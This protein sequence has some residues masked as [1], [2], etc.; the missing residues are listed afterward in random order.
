MGL[1]KKLV[2]IFVILLVVV[3]AI[4]IYVLQYKNLEVGLDDGQSGVEVMGPQDIELRIVL[5]FTNTGS[6]EL[7][8]PPTDFEVWVDGIYAGPGKSDRV[9]VPA[10][11]TVWTTAIVSI[12]HSSVP[13]AFAALVDPGKDEIRLKGEAHVEVGPFTFDFPFDETYKVE[14]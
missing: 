12:G 14:T 6:I 9:E 7:A 8:V 3:F 5:R 13:L 1:A 10:G 4:A 2:V 11:G